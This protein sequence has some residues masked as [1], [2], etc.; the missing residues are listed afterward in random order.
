MLG[1]VHEGLV[2]PG[3][4]SSTVVGDYEYY[5]YGCDG[6]DDR[7]WGCGYRTLQSICSW[8]GHQNRPRRHNNVTNAQ[9]D[10]GNKVPTLPEI[11]AALVAMGDK[12][13]AFCGSREWIGSF[14]VCI[15]VDHFRDVACKIVH[16]KSGSELPKHLDD[17]QQ[18]FE[19][20]GSPVMMGEWQASYLG[21][22]VIRTVHP[23]AF[24]E[25]ALSQKHY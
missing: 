11:Q 3:S 25:F 13:A 17:L 22:A 8:V 10:I 2:C 12:P 5:H 4:K 21:A 1:N 16:V 15:C 18:H 20:F 9:P 6:T 7:G 24:W 19:E 23:S 14:E